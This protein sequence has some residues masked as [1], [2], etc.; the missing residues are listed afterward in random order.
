MVIRISFDLGRAAYSGEIEHDVGGIR[1]EIVSVSGESGQRVG[2]NRTVS[3]RSDAG[4]H[5]LSLSVRLCEA[6]CSERRKTECQFT[7]IF[8]VHE[9]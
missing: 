1:T 6:S 4:F 7:E 2:G 3:E 8:E 9:L 5:N